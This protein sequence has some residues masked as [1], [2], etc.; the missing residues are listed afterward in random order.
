MLLGL[1]TP[2]NSILRYLLNPQPLPPGPDRF[3]SRFIIVGGG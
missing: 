3:R 2:Y 1:Y